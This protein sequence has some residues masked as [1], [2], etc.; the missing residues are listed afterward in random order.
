[1][2]Q[3]FIDQLPEFTEGLTAHL[4]N[5]EY[6]ALGALAHKAKS[7]VAV[8]GM[9]SLANDLKTLEINAKSG[10]DPDQYPEL[11]NRFIEQVTLTATELEAYAKTFS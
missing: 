2:I 1:M 9:N 3:L 6:D 7:S 4:S 11:V 5:G 8:M 10:T